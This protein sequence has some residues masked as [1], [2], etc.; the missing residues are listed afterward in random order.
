MLETFLRIHVWG[1]KHGWSDISG[2]TFFDTFRT[3]LTNGPV[4]PIS[5]ISYLRSVVGSARKSE[6][7]G[8]A[9]ASGP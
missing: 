4:F 7:T 8:K 3:A 2:Q 5:F 9:G 1:L 6:K